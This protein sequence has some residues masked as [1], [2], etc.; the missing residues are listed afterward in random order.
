MLAEKLENLRAVLRAYGSCLVAYS[1][2]VDSVFLARV[3]HDVL[4]DNFNAELIQF[5]GKPQGVGILPL[6]SQHF[7]ADGDNPGIHK[8][9]GL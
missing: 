4:G 8:R 2:G 7:R 3:A 5:A 1:G 9:G 6:R